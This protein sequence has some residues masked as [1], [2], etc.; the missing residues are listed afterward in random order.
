MSVTRFWSFSRSRSLNNK[1]SSSSNALTG[2]QETFGGG[3][4]DGDADWE[5]DSSHSDSSAGS[6]DGEESTSLGLEVL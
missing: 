3:G 5:S 4:I 1:T 6:Q 2:D